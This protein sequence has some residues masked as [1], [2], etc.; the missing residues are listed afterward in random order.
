TGD[1]TLENRLSL[2]VGS[3]ERGGRRRLRARPGLDWPLPNLWNRQKKVCRFSLDALHGRTYPRRNHGRPRGGGTSLK[4]G[5]EMVR[6][7]PIVG[8]LAI[9]LGSSPVQAVSKCDAG[10]S[11]AIGKFVSCL[12]GA[13]SKSQK[14]GT[15]PDFGKCNDK[16]NGATGACQKAQSKGDCV[17]F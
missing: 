13:Y 12:C 7:L 17:I 16:F 10:V 5:T 1:E 6:K 11:K 14:K 9:V 8:G 15:V 2:Q 4:G 3:R